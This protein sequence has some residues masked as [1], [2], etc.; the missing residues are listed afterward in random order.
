MTLL[1]ELTSKSSQTAASRIKD[2]NDAPRGEQCR[3]QRVS[4][5]TVH[6]RYGRRRSRG[7]EQARRIEDVKEVEIAEPVRAHGRSKT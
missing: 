1:E 3:C 6:E 5:V 4:L 7:S 2:E